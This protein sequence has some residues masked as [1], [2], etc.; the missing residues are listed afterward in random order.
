MITL[1]APRRLAGEAKPW[2]KLGLSASGLVRFLNRARAAV[3]LEGEVHVLL[4]D[5]A[6]LKRLNRAGRAIWRSRWSRRR[7]RRR[8]VATR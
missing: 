4:A 6:P 8:G 1:E 5:D 7:G 2:Q 3:G